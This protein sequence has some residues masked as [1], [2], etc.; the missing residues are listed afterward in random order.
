MKRS[1]FPQPSGTFSW[2]YLY[3][4]GRLQPMHYS[5]TTSEYY[6]MNKISASHFRGRPR[7]HSA[8]E[9]WHHDRTIVQDNGYLKL[10]NEDI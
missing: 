4:D 10:L 2:Y 6:C 1:D 8:H 5:P 3:H 7:Y 9:D